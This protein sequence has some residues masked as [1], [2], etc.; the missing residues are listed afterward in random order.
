VKLEWMA[1]SNYAEDRGGLLYVVGGGFDTLNV[2]APIEGAPAGVFAVMQ[3]ML[4]V[5]LLMA[6]TETGQNHS[7]TLEIADEDGQQIL[8]ALAD[9][10]TERSP[11]LPIG[12]DQG[13][14]LIF[15]LTGIGLP[16][17]GNYTINL[18]VGDDLLGDRPFRVLKLY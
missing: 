13:A 7:L 17:P 14:N 9:F 8:K 4:V 10:R 15:P 2:Q 12:W 18:W 3:G 11:G 1:L 5:R 16:K 6:A